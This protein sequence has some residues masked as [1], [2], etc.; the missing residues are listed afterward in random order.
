MLKKFLLVLYFPASFLRGV[1]EN[2]SHRR[3][4]R[5]AE[6]IGE[7]LGIGGDDDVD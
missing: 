4:V 3:A 1:R 5:Q 2:R 7:H 6:Y